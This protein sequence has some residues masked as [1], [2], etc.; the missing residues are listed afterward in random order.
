[1]SDIK[2]QL[3][4][5]CASELGIAGSINH[6]HNKYSDLLEDKLETIIKH[7]QDREKELI[8][9][10]RKGEEFDDKVDDLLLKYED[11]KD[12]INYDL[13]EEKRERNRK[14]LSEMYIQKEEIQN[15]LSVIKSN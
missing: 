5:K 2:E 14:E 8:R 10:I 9:K 15:A 12:W 7:L 4:K 6:L 13:H 11:E 3:R 1:M